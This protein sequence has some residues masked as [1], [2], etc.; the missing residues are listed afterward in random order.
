MISVVVIGYGNVGFHL[1][2]AFLN[3]KTIDLLE[4]YSRD[5]T[6]IKLLEK[7][8]AITNQLDK[9]KDADI[10]IIS[11]SD[12]AI[13]EVSSKIKNQNGII[14][15]TSGAVAM[16]QLQTN[17]RKGVFY[18]LQ[19]FSKEKQIDFKEIPLCLETEHQ[20]DYLILEEI[21]KAIGEKIYPINSAQRQ[22]LHV[23][24]VFVN[25]FTNHMFKIGNDICNQHNVP[26]DVL[27]PLI[28]ETALKIEK[29][30]P[31]KA[32][33][34]PAIRKDKKTIAKHLGFLNEQQQNIYKLLT[35]SIQ[36][37]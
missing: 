34:G 6:K 18:P 5:I 33:T 20:S 30:P 28:K 16:N 14:V 37:G 12:D 9:L 15:H 29:L 10:Y 23:A 31:E 24:A 22:L 11:V 1:V 27:L 25:N 21:A 17:N 36:N 19:S 3:S 26:F 35:Q 2:N 8:V 32:Q 13:P 4:V 7:K